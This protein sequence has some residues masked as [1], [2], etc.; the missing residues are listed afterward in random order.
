MQR[1]IPRKIKVYENGNTNNLSPN[2]ESY[3]VFTKRKL[4]SAQIDKYKFKENINLLI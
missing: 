4:I 2:F 3:V 1:N